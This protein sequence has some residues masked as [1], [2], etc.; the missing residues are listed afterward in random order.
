MALK[1]FIQDYMHWGERSVQAHKYQGV[2]GLLHPQLIIQSENLRA[3]GDFKAF[4][5]KLAQP[6]WF[7]PFVK[8]RPYN[9][10]IGSY[11][12][13]RNYVRDNLQGCVTLQ[14]RPSERMIIDLISRK[15]RAL[16]PPQIPVNLRPRLGYPVIGLFN[17]RLSNA[18]PTMLS[19]VARAELKNW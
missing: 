3:V 16:H 13:N 18:W 8:T 12:Q 15:F 10:I 19:N 14:F 11:S 9:W 2:W 5:K 17:P 1:L 7:Q 6:E 4:Q